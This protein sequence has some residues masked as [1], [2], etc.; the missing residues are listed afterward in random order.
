MYDDLMIT[1]FNI[2]FTFLPPL[3]VACL[4]KDIPERVIKEVVFEC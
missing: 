1:F 3:F 2:F 4:E